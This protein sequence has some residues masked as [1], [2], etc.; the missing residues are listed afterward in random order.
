LKPGVLYL[1]HNLDDFPRWDDGIE[2]TAGEYFN[3]LTA[4][5]A[6]GREP[7]VSQSFPDESRRHYYPHSAICYDY[8]KLSDDGES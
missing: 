6:A 1:A 3:E 8:R 4:A 2:I 7:G 5:K